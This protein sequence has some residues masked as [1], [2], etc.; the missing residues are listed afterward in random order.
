[1]KRDFGRG[2]AFT[3]QFSNM[4]KKISERSVPSKGFGDTTLTIVPADPSIEIPE[5]KKNLEGTTKDDMTKK[6]E[7]KGAMQ[8]EKVS[9]VGYWLPRHEMVKLMAECIDEHNAESD[10]KINFMMGKECVGILPTKKAGQDNVVCVTVKDVATGSLIKL[11]QATLV[12]G[13]DGMKSK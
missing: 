6:E 9:A 4:Q 12:V 11:H 10:C 13:A 5:Q 3:K 8:S 1:V 7:V 2:Q